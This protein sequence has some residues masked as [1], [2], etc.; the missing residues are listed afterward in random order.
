MKYSC[1][2]DRMLCKLWEDSMSK[3][4]KS[5]IDNDFETIESLMKILDQ[6]N[7]TEISLKTDDF[8][9]VLK[10]EFD[11]KKE[12]ANKFIQTNL[13]IPLETKKEDNSTYV[14]IISE[15]IGRYFYR[16]SETAKTKVE[17]GNEIKVGDDIG[18]ILTLGVENPI[19]SKF[20]GIVDDILVDNGAPV[21]F[22]KKL[23][24]LKEKL[25]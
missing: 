21:D 12:L 18:Y 8:S 4:K 17:K 24:R 6:K 9:I 7:L 14:D 23:I 3:D 11:P 2:N 13:E 15:N 5:N 25:G 20:S 16:A 10:G 19:K 22:G 1:E